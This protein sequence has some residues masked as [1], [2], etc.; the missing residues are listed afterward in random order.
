MNDA[1]DAANLT[2]VFLFLERIRAEG[3]EIDGGTWGAA[4]NGCKVAG[5]PGVASFCLEQMALANIS[6]NEVHFRSA[7]A[8]YAGE[9]WQRVNELVF[10]AAHDGIDTLDRFFVNVHV[11]SLLGQLSRTSRVRSLEQAQEL[12]EE[13]K[14]EHQQAALDV[15]SR[16][17]AR[18]TDM[19][20]FTAM[21]RRAL[22][23][24]T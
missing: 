5:E 7:V 4:L 11:A 8:A 24:Q 1:A 21:V 22:L 19:L 20:K 9:P 23:K 16:A 6:A 10:K 17:R 2:Q 18:G 14:P 13:A 12:V 15:I 3:L